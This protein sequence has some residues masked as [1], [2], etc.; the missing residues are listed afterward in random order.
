MPDGFTIQMWIS[1]ERVMLIY[2]IRR[3]LEGCVT[4]CIL[5]VITFFL[6]RL[7]PGGPFDTDQVWPPEIQANINKQYELD[8]PLTVQFAHW[9][10]DLLHGNLRESFQYIGRPVRTIIAD[11]LPTSLVLGGSALICAVLL[12]IPLGCLAAWNRHTPWDQLA[13]AFFATALSLPSYLLASLLILAFSFGLGWFPPALWEN[14]SSMVLPIA[15]LAL[16]PLAIIGRLTRASMLE[17]MGADYIRT[18]YGKGLPRRAIIFK[19][20]LKNSLIPVLTV[21]GPLASN[22]VTGSFLIEM[23]FQIPGMGKYFVQAVLNR[24]YPLVMGVTL[25]YGVVLISSNLVVDLSYA[26]VDP[27]I[28]LG[29]RSS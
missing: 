1:Y 11:S 7:T 29:E 23:I 28:R 4:L 22:L 6:L 2:G 19:H 26:W 5:A 14:S 21:L 15:S 13:V 3:I 16:R 25:I 10:S 27:R 8:Q 24:D 9:A 17:V 18:A 20:A 12:G